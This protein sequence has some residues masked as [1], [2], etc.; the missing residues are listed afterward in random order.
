M[1]KRTKRW[2]I[3]AISFSILFWL[4]IGVKAKWYPHFIVNTS[5]MEPALP[6]DKWVLGKRTGDYGR[7][8][9][10]F[11]IYKHPQSGTSIYMHRIVGEPGDTLQIRNDIVYIN[12]SVSDPYWRYKYLYKAVGADLRLL[13]KKGIVHPDERLVMDDTIVI[14]LPPEAAV[15]LSKDP[16]VKYFSLYLQ[17]PGA[18]NEPI[19]ETYG[20]SWNTDNFGPYIV[21]AGHYFIMGDNRHNAADSRYTGP[22]PAKDIQGIIY[23]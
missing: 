13:E 6:K 15:A 14:M 17:P 21:P 1:N 19:R 16:V 18:V 22:V 9:I 7:G 5:S 3:I 11:Y 4:L 10:V 20:K 23:N 12:D 2:L 8:D